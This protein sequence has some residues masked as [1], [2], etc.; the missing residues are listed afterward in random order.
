MVENSD[1]DEFMSIGSTKTTFTLETSDEDELYLGLWS[2]ETRR[3]E[4]SDA[5]EFVC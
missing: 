4:N 2:E 3:I 1:A 5:D